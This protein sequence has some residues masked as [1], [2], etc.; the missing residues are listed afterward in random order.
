MMGSVP[1]WGALGENASSVDSDAQAFHGQHVVV[2][3]AGY[4]MH[5]ITM[6]DGSVVKEFASPAGVV[7]AVSWQG[8][9]IPDLHQLLGS[10]LTNLQQGQRTQWIPRRAVTVQ[11]NDFVLSSFGRMRSFRG[12]AYVPSLVPANLTMEAVQ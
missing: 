8:H 4:N 11:G 2:A 7:F 5:Q 12:R 1:A 9:S 6:Q 10:Y 3:K